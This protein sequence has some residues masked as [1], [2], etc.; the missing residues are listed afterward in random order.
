MWKSPRL[1]RRFEVKGGEPGTRPWFETYLAAFNAGDF[2]GFGAFYDPQVQFEGQ[3]ASLTGR[4]AVLDFYRMVHSRVDEHVGLLT[5]VGSS[6]H[7]AAEIVTTLDPRKDWPD[8][9]TGALKAGERRQSVNFAL[10]DIREERFTRIR[11]ARFRRL[12]PPS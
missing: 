8:F 4:N 12:V 10:Y 5:F 9:P 6:S 7:C 3:A 2:E 1:R 11:S